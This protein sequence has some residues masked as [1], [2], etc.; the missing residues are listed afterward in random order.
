MS[1]PATIKIAHFSAG[2][3]SAVAAMGLPHANCIPC[4]KA[5][6]PGYWALIRERFPEEFA[7]MVEL[8]RLKG[9][10][11]FLSALPDD[12][13]PSAAEAPSCDLLCE[14]ARRGS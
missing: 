3:S 8:V 9:E 7:R 14:I 6:S 10:R 4:P 12:I 13:V 2:A 5:T 11:R 1:A